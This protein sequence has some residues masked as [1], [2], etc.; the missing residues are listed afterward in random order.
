M[1][2][3]LEGIA[4]LVF[5]LDLPVSIAL[6]VIANHVSVDVFHS[7]VCCKSINKYIAIQTQFMLAEWAWQWCASRLIPNQ[8]MTFITHTHTRG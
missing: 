8:V 2:F 3:R 5:C 6:H 1:V 7:W 4:G